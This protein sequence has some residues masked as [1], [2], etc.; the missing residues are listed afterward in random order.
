MYFD[1]EARH[2]N[3]KMF[4][5]NDGT[6]V[7]FQAVNDHHNDCPD[8]SDEPTHQEES[9]DCTLGNQQIH[10]ARERRAC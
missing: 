2:A 9:Y 5:C 7:P 3:N 6:T 8:A 1:G 10:V 4:T